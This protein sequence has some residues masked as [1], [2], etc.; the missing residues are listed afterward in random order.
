[1]E[2]L[3]GP[4]YAVMTLVPLVTLAAIIFI[5]QGETERAVE[6]LACASSAAND[7][8]RW[9]EKLPFLMRLYDELE[10]NLG[11][12]IYDAV[13]ERGKQLELETVWSELQTEIAHWT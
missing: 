4:F 10:A 11:S 13:W 5:H 12:A 2:Y 1:M 3:D 6:W 9:L 8:V 7:T